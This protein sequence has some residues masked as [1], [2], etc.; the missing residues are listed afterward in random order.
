MWETPRLRFPLHKRTVR[1][2]LWVS[3]G[4]LQLVTVRV[5]WKNI[6]EFCSWFRYRYYV[7][8]VLL[9]ENCALISNIRQ[10]NAEIVYILVMQLSPTKI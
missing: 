8:A 9:S 7:S 4:G 2:F 10:I 6:I 5:Q 1:H 3:F